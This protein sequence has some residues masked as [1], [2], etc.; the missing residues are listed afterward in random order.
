M[1]ENYQQSQIFLAKEEL[2]NASLEDIVETRNQIFGAIKLIIENL[3]IES[4]L[5]MKKYS[6]ANSQI[7]HWCISTQKSKNEGIVK[8]AIKLICLTIDVSKG[9]AV[10]SGINS[11]VGTQINEKTDVRYKTSSSVHVDVNYRGIGLGSEIESI[12]RNFIQFQADNLKK[13]I[14]RTETNNNYGKGKPIEEKRWQ[15]IFSSQRNRIY[16]EGENSGASKN[17]V[18]IDNSTFD[19]DDINAVLENSMN[20]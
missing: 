2:K 18:L 11:I 6:S 20:N 1:Q 9:I 19:L 7:E 13:A 16:R 12:I 14:K 4:N 3:K 5:E 15:A 8:K 17:M 10:A